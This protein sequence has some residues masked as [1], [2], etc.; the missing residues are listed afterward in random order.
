MGKPHPVCKD[1]KIDS[2]LHPV[3]DGAWPFLVAGVIYL[4]S[5]DNEL[6]FILLSSLSILHMSVLTS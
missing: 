5:P 3:V 2:F 4:V 6:D 1:W